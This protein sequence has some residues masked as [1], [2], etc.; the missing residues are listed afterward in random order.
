MSETSTSNVQKMALFT[1]HNLQVLFN[2][3]SLSGQ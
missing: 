2:E 1:F 3:W